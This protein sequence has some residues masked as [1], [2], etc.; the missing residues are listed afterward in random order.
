MRP[1][2]G[3][4]TPQADRL[5]PQNLEAEQV[6]LGAILIESEAILKA[7]EV[8]LEEDFYRRPHRQIY[9]AMLALFERNEAI[10][11]VTVSEELKKTGQFEEA[12]GTEYLSQLANQTPTAANIWYYAKIVKDKSLQR[13]ILRTTTEV[14]ERVYQGD[15]LAEELM[16]MAEKKIFELSEKRIKASFTSMKDAIKDT[17]KMLESLRKENITG[18]SSGFKDLDEYTAG[19]H[20]GDLIIVGGRPSSGKTAFGLNIAQYVGIQ[21]K[22]PV[23]VFSL[24]MSLRQIIIRM[25]CSESEVDASSI[26]RGYVKQHWSDLATAAGK[27]VEAPIYVDDTSAISALEMRAKARRLKREHGLSLI[28]VDYLQLMKGS[29]NYEQR[30]Q[31]ISE[32]SRSLKSLAKEL[33]VPVVALSQL[34]RAVE[35]ERRRPNMSDL[36]ESGAI[37]QDADVILFLYRDDT[38]RAEGEPEMTRNAYVVNLDIAKQRNGPTTARPIP[39]TFLANCTRFR[40]S[41]LERA[42]DEGF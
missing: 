36:R 39:L 16:D 3:P 32:I 17:F 15:L 38:E 41:Y 40:D 34:N 1:E 11:I 28:I 6:V 21:M 27:L 7:I 19:F 42:E 37:E 9:A 33:D 13:G 2:T 29:G 24:E 10:D 30:V 25:L 14:A 5:P 26:R 22:E 4:F 31:E 12:G 20:P 18:M 35:R 23:A 8:L